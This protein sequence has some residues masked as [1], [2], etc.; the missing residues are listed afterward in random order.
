MVQSNQDVPGWRKA[1]VIPNIVRYVLL[2]SNAVWLEEHR[3]NL[4]TCNE[5]NLLWSPTKDSG[6]L[7]RQHPNQKLWQEQPSLWSKKNGVRSHMS[8]PTEDEP[9]KVFLGSFKWQVPWIY[10]HI[11]RNLSWPW[12]D[13][14]HPRYATSKEPQR[15]QG[16][17]KQAGYIC[18]FIVN[19]SG[20]YQPS[21]RLM[22]KG[23]S[24]V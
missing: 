21:T 8:S 4:P 17:T 19:L 14:I 11:Q 23:M 1:Y 12:Q 3:C 16:F 22:K 18:R 13:Q 24:F 5:H 6:K 2:Y 20:H 9:N 10:C 7:C 15:T